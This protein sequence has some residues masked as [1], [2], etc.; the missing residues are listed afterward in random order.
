MNRSIWRWSDGIEAPPP[1]ARITLGEGDTPVVRSRRL[2][3]ACGLDHLYFKLELCNPTGSYKDRFAFCAISHMLA[4][5][6]DRCIATTSGNTGSSLAA[7]CA[8][9]GLKCF[10]AVVETAP[11]GKLQQMLSYGANIFRVRQFGID[12]RISR[13]TFEVLVELGARSDIALQI[14]AF[15]FS[16]LGMS[17]VR[18]LAFEL[19]DQFPSPIDHV[20]TQAGG[21]GLTWAVAQGFE[22]LRAAGRIRN[23]PRVECVQPSGNNTIAGPLREGLDRGQDVVCSSRISGLQ[24]ANVIDGH[25]AIRACRASG[26]T[27]HLVDD[28]YVWEIQRRLAREEGIFCEPAGAVAVAGAIQAARQGRIAREAVTVAL[29]TGSGFKDPPSVER[30]IADRDCPLIE[31]EELGDRMSR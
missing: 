3:P 6:K 7:Y 16:P 21:G 10:I 1:A 27:G 14:S 30:M 11:L 5:G 13:G 29:V 25:D 15:K 19:A 4:A 18:T 24:V 20:F 26:G 8:A 9:A 31:L 2:G 22:W 17:G 12:P 23:T 28:D